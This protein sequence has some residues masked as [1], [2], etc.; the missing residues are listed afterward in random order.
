[1][2]E[3]SREVGRDASFSPDE[4]V[5]QERRKYK[6]IAKPREGYNGNSNQVGRVQF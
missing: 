4:G 1:M 3:V 6:K 2:I 5:W